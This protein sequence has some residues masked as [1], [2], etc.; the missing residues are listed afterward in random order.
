V[1][2]IMDVVLTCVSCLPL[3]LTTSVPV[4][5]EFVVLLTTDPVLMVGSLSH[6]ACAHCCVLIV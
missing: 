4:L 2:V 1:V 6:S 3:H 5:L